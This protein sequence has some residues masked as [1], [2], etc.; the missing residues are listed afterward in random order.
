MWYNFFIKFFILLY[1]CSGGIYLRE[2]IN[3]KNDLKKRYEDAISNYT[4]LGRNLSQ[5]IEMFL[6]DHS[7]KF[8]KVYYRIKGTDSFIEKIDRKKFTKPFEEIQDICGIRIICYYKSD[9]PKICEIISNEFNVLTSQD[10]EELLEPDQFGYRSHHFIVK[11]KENWLSVPNYKGLDDLKAEVQ[12]RTNLMHTWAE[13]EHE[14]GYKKE[15]DIPKEF[16]REFSLLSASLETVDNQ[17][18][19]LKND[20]TAYREQNKIESAYKNN[21]ELNLDTLQAFLDDY[22]PEREKS[23]NY[24][25]ELVSELNALGISISDI[26][27]LFEKSKHLLSDL[28]QDE[29]RILERVFEWAQVGIV[30]AILT[31]TV[32]SYLEKYEMPIE[33]KDL[34]LKYREKLN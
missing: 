4:K 16:R 20:I 27:G 2:V 17:F 24:T 7:I 28:E 5:V 33:I 14:L 25:S 32:D 13:I 11:I 21:N 26:I 30:R 34:V 9:I 29:N 3:P 31:L 10:K 12:I 23:E 15:D 1:C 8:L 22:F 19:R 6:E 18:E